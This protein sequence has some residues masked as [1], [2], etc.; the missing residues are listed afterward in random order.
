MYLITKWFGTFLIKDNKIIKKKLF[1]KD[2]KIIAKNLKKIEN[3][4]ILLEEKSI[5]KKFK[6]ENIIVNEKR[7][8]KIGEF[9]PEDNHFK[10][11][12]IKSNDYNYDKNIL[13]KASIDLVK[14]KV[15]KKL[16]S[17]D[18]QII[19]MV[20][21]LD[22]LIQITNLL[23]ERLENWLEIYTPKYKIKPYKKTILK[24][25]KETNRIEEQIKKDIIKIAPNCSNIVGPIITAR[26]IALA[27]SIEKLSKM[28]ASTIQ[29][30]GAE[31][32]FFRYKK[33][34]GKNPKHGII[35]QHPI[36]NKSPKKL[37][38][39]ISRLIANKLAIAI[40]A[41][42]FTHK[43]ISN[44]LKNDIKKKI[45]EIKNAKK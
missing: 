16:K 21:T 2:Y 27:G 19:Q 26:M 6:K 22:S 12:N 25:N 18:Y 35:Y 20:K 9:N 33:E 15:D 44:V 5:I 32:A 36:I 8:E 34:G 39:K 42:Y 24:I 43:D 30:L 28:P 1:S 29:I 40:K 14:D 45:N 10:M 17:L 31:N 37:R 7:L 3:N 4:N 41:D 38:G 11:Y 23:N 13:Q